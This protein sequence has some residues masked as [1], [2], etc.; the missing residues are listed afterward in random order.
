[1]RKLI[2]VLLLSSSVLAQEA[3]KKPEDLLKKPELTEVQKLELVTVL[4]QLQIAQLRVEAAEK[5]KQIATEKA[6]ALLKQRVVAGWNLNLQKL[7]YE[8]EIKLPATVPE[9][10]K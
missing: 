4:Q 10:V 2:F 8:P 5:E 6:Q 3:P 9:A 1:M 7:D